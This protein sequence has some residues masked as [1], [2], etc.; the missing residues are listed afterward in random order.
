MS[1]RPVLIA[2][3]VMFCSSVSFAGEY[4]FDI[5]EIE[6]KPF[7]VGGYAELRPSLFGLDRDAALYQ[8]NFYDRDEGKTIEKVSGKLQLEGTYERGVAKLFARINSDLSYSY[9]GWDYGIDMYEVYLS[10]K[11]Y[12]SFTI[13]IGK[14]TFKWGKGYAWNPVAFIDRPKDPDNPE[15]AL[16]GFTAASVDFIKSFKGPLQTFSLTPVLLPVY[17]HINDDFGE[18]D[19]LNFAGKLY[20]LLYDTDIDFLFLTGESRTNRFGVDFSRNITTNFEIHGEFAYINDNIRKVID[21][22]GTV[23][24]TESDAKACLLGIRYLTRRDTTFILEYYHNET[25]FSRSEME[26]YFAFIR[27]GYDIFLS[28]E[29]DSLLRKAGDITEGVYGRPNPMR[30]YLY[31]KASQKEPF[32]ILYFTP[33]LTSIVNLLDR[34]FSLS[35]ELLYTGFTNWELLLKGAALFGGWGTEYGEKQNDYRI[36]VGV[37]YYF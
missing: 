9:S 18:I 1:R 31:M 16:E 35:P 2:A 20:L 8:L 30:E 29:D 17:A 32:N 10:L 37:K 21:G 12:T 36:D 5:S 14:R 15:L 34:S 6:K 7:R 13:D 19:H 24:E 3:I 23:S 22:T 26:D 33:A 4:E 25:G 27:S 28:T 11:P